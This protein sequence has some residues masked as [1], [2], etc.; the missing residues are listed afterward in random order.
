MTGTSKRDLR[1]LAYRKSWMF[2]ADNDDIILHSD[3]TCDHLHSYEVYLMGERKGGQA[4]SKGDRRGERGTGGE[5]RGQEG[6][7]GGRHCTC[8]VN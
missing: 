3:Q 6:D 8:I 2:E 7:Y 4:G 1:Q 5:E